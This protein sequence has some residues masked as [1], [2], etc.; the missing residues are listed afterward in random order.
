MRRTEGVGQVPAIGS[1][2]AL[3]SLRSH[4]LLVC[5]LKMCP[6]MNNSCVS[7]LTRV[8]TDEQPELQVS[9]TV[10]AVTAA[11]HWGH[12]RKKKSR[13]TEQPEEF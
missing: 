10:S 6:L 8:S 3:W 7:V 9:D 12:G 13:K 5:A 4:N 11:I 2:V 1:M